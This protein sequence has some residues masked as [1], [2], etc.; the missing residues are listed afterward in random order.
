MLLSNQLVEDARLLQGYGSSI[1]NQCKDQQLSGMAVSS[2]RLHVDPNAK[3]F[4]VHTPT[5]VSIHWHDVVKEQLDGGV[6]M[7]VIE[8]VLIGELSCWCHRMVVARMLD[9]TSRQTVDLSPLNVCCLCETHHIKSPFP[10]KLCHRTPG[11]Q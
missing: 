5:P 9:G 11:N 8:K 3:S 4:T 1:F 7:R 6:P 10:Q 2:I